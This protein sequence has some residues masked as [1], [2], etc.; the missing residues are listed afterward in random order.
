VSAILGLLF[1][2]IRIALA[3]M[4]VEYGGDRS[5]NT[6]KTEMDDRKVKRARQY[7]AAPFEAPQWLER[8]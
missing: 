7:F 3:E 5:Y 4:T 6:A 8:M 2:V 1:T